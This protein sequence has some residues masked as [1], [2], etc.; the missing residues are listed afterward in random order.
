M[1]MW[2]KERER[3]WVKK[4]VMGGEM[5]TGRDWIIS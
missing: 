3:E 4:R 2:G 1:S 5:A